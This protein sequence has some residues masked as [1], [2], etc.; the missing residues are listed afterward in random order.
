MKNKRE[1]AI[2][3][4]ETPGRVIFINITNSQN[5]RV[6]DID[7]DDSQVERRKMAQERRISRK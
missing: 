5:R 7:F 6:G 4:I 1:P 2:F 3:N